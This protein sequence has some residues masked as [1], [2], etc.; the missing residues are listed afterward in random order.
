MDSVK[1][2]STAVVIPGL[3]RSLTLVQITDMHLTGADERDTQRIREYAPGR[4]KH[5]TVF[6]GRSIEDVFESL[7]KYADAQKADCVVLTGDILD[8]L[9]PRNT[10]ALDCLLVRAGKRFFFVNGN[11]EHDGDD[12]WGDLLRPFTDMSTGCGILEVGGVRLI[13]VDDS[14][15]R[16]TPGQL[17][18]L[19]EQI[20]DGK[21][22]LL[23]MHIPLYEETLEEPTLKA[24]QGGLIL[25]GIPEVA[26]KKQTPGSMFFTPLP[27][28]TTLEFCRVAGEAA[29]IYGVFAGHLHFTHAGA[30]PSGHC[31]YVTGPGYENGCREIRV[32]PG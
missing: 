5:F 1:A 14:M 22:C 11:H 9:T 10:E 32:V 8:F 28:Q 23:F 21:P 27:D 29:N 31:Q 2:E 3:E 19:K 16:V 6:P 13:G 30:L 4:T 26:H 24:W 25:L 17:E 7:L 20:A 15:N 12:L 18:F